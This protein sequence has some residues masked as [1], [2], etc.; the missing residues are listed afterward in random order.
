MLASHERVGIC[1]CIVCIVYVLCRSPSP[2][3]QHH[4]AHNRLGG[5][6]QRSTPREARATRGDREESCCPTASGWG[7]L[8]WACLTTYETPVKIRVESSVGKKKQK[9]ANSRAMLW[10]RGQIGYSDQDDAA[11]RTS[12]LPSGHTTQ[13][14]QRA[15]NSLD[16]F[17][18]CYCISGRIDAGL[19]GCQPASPPV[20]QSASPTAWQTGGES[21]DMVSVCG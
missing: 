8:F 6:S 20:L 16:N 7:G 2:G 9:F 11:S 19:A 21:D 1:T 14:R 13:M 18:V 10:R 4:Q 5:V 17:R 15:E 12:A 3:H